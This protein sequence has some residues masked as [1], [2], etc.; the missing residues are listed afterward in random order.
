MSFEE[1]NH[2]EESRNE[3]LRTSAITLFHG[4][5][6]QGRVGLHWLEGR[7]EF[8]KRGVCHSHCR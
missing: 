1:D 5:S 7:D 4:S 3:H 8:V 2:E 6:C